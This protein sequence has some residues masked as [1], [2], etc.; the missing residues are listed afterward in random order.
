MNPLIKLMAGQANEQNPVMQMLS[1][2]SEFKK[3]WTPQAAQAK[4][5]E[6]VNTGQV[7]PQQLEQARQMAE[8]FKH[9]IK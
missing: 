7:S 8:K 1:K 3:N 5:N 2:F 9:I 6:M 4:I